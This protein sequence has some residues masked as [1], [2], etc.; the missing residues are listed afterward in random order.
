MCLF[1]VFSQHGS[2][3]ST[4]PLATGLYHPRRQTP[5][6][7][8]HFFSD[9]LSDPLTSVASAGPAASLA[10]VARKFERKCC[11]RQLRPLTDLHDSQGLAPNH[12]SGRDLKCP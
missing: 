1:L 6:S 7:H 4:P 9:P 2:C 8:E 5:P 3:V 11:D 12:W 10:A